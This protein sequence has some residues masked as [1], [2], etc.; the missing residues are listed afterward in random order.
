L[1]IV[2]SKEACYPQRYKER[3]KNTSC[4]RFQASDA[5][6]Y[7]ERSLGT[8]CPGKTIKNELNRFSLKEE[9]SRG[10]KRYSLVS[11]KRG[12]KSLSLLCEK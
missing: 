5:V 9:A 2:P 10:T 3:E 6:R 12:Y 4:L 1:Q 7:E 8:G 11:N